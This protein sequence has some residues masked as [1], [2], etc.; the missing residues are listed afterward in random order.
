M[1]LKKCIIFYHCD[2][3]PL[4]FVE[5]YVT[6]ALCLFKLQRYETFFLQPTLY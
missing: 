2:Q 1:N 5:M 4:G 6:W 3:G